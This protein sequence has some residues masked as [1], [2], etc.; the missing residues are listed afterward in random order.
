MLWEIICYRE[1]T[2]RNNASRPPEG[3]SQKVWFICKI[4]PIISWWCIFQG[5]VCVNF[6]NFDHLLFLS[7][8]DLEPELFFEFWPWIRPDPNPK[9]R[10]RPRG[11]SRRRPR[12][13]YLWNFWPYCFEWRKILIFGQYLILWNLY[14]VPL[15]PTYK[16]IL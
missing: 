13:P 12:A 1:N 14:L 16:A 3:W 7:I 9:N 15:R 5:T 8:M 6:T 11:Q 10:A 2:H 4:Q